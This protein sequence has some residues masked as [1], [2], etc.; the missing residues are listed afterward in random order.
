MYQALPSARDTAMQIARK[1]ALEKEMK[2]LETA[3]EKLNKK[4]L[5]VYNDD[6]RV[7]GWAKGQAL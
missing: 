3:L 6:P 2:S 4:V 7:G 5:Y 1:E